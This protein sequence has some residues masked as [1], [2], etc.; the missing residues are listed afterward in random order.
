[1]HLFKT[2]ARQG[3]LSS[4]APRVRLTALSR[5]ALPMRSLTVG[6]TSFSGAGGGSAG[7]GSAGTAG[8]SKCLVAV[9]FG[10]G[11]SL[12]MT[13]DCMK[14]RFAPRPT[15]HSPNPDSDTRRLIL[16]V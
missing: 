1:M 13:A 6:L 7:G 8:M 5:S 11:A 16:G 4:A 12:Q 10:A 3:R 15:Y 2:M 14:V 9:A